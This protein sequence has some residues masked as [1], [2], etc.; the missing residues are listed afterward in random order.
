MVRSSACLCAL[1]A[2]CGCR[3][4]PPPA[5]TFESAAPPANVHPRAA[6]AS[7]TVAVYV[8][9]EVEHPGVYHLGAGS[10]IVD[11]L[12]LAGDAK[13][14]ADLVAVN[15][16]EPLRD[17]AEIAVPARGVPHVARARTP[18]ARAQRASRGN[19]RGHKRATVPDAPINLNT[20]DAAALA[21]LPGVG[22]GLAERIVQFREANGPFDSVDELV[23]VSGITGRRLESLAPYVT[24]DP[25]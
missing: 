18:R 1:L 20:A 25:R 23:D 19:R 17:G 2:V 13:P 12:H 15:L 14:D 21:A 4:S 7:A 6:A 9:G 10:R 16:A 24:V 8:A 11:A 22:E 5:V 3:D